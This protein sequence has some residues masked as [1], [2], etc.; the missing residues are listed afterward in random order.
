VSEVFVVERAAFFGGDWPQGFTPLAGAAAA[1]FLARAAGA[2]RFVDRPTAER[3]PAWK[4]WIPY[5]VLVSRAPGAAA[6]DGV[7]LVRRTNGQTEA[8]LHGAWSIGL[9]GH[10]EPADGAPA[11]DGAA[12]FAAALARELA[13]ELALDGQALPAATFL[14]LLNDDSTEV[15]RVHAGLVYRLELPCEV[16]AAARRVAVGETGKMAGG[17]TLLVEFARVWQNLAPFETWSS[18]LVRAGVVGSFG[19]PR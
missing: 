15:G 1:D 18:M 4:Q 8:R 10:V 5:C 12:F 19:A 6:Y 17:F 11:G 13:E 9:G 16:A 3:T 2:G 7:F 14:G